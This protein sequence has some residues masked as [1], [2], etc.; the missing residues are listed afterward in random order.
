MNSLQ[1]FSWLRCLG[2]SGSFPFP[3]TSAVFVSC[4]ES[5]ELKSQTTRSLSFHLSICPVVSPCHGGLRTP[6]NAPLSSLGL[7]KLHTT[8]GM[9]RH[10]VKSLLRLPVA[11]AAQP[12][13]LCLIWSLFACLSPLLPFLSWGLCSL[14]QLFLPYFGLSGFHDSIFSPLY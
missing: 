12:P 1:K 2:H 10:K 4:S 6:P 14:P 5:L 11:P 8:S 7:S 3:P 13:G 9:N